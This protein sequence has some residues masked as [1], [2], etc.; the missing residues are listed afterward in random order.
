MIGIYVLVYFYTVVHTWS[1]FIG[2]YDNGK[3]L[4]SNTHVEFDLNYKL[5]TSYICIVPNGAVN[6][7]YY[8]FFN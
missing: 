3:I 5:T 6:I 4:Y 8:N 1:N 7:E 2:M